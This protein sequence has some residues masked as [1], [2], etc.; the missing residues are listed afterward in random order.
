MNDIFI[1]KLGKTVGLN[2]QLKIHIDTDFPEQ[3]QKNKTFVTHK[4]QI[5]TIQTINLKNK[6]VKFQNI[7]SVEEASKYVNSQLFT[8]LEDTKINCTLQKDQ[9]FWFD[10]IGCSIVENNITLGTIK[11][12]HRY[13]IDDYFEITTNTKLLNEE[14]KAKTFLLPYNKTY[15]IN[16]DINNK[17]IEVQNAMHIFENS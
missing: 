3:F 14:Y 12:I 6:I 11:D 10:L 13:P 7:D 5:L 4:K 15:I 17:T 9:Y 1:A 8:S 2:G 16:V